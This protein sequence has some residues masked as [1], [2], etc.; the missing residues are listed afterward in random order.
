M[1]SDEEMYNGIMAGHEDNQKI[2]DF[3]KDIQAR[4]RQGKVYLPDADACQ[5]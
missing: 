1:V 4:D 2:I 5:R 3:I